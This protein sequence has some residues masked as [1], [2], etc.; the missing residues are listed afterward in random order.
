LLPDIA[1]RHWLV[2][3]DI[4]DTGRTLTAL[5]E[6][7]RSRNPA[8]IRTAVLLWKEGRQEVDLTP[9]FHAFRIP[10]KFVVGYGLDYAE[11]Y[12]ALPFVGTLARRVY[13]S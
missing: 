6:E 3:D 10:D 7:L 1:G 12:R 13:R 4:L 8:S 9:D 5:C 11:R 2:V